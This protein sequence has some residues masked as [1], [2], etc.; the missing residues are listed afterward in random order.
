LIDGGV[1]DNNPA[2]VTEQVTS[3]RKNIVMM[4]RPYPAERTGVQGDRLY[5]APSIE[6][7]ADCWDYRRDAP[8]EGNLAIGEAEALRHASALDRLLA[9]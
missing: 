9:G 6:L 4:T 2:F 7:P 1:I 5:V 8:I 3:V